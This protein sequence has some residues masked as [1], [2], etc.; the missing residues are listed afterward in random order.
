MK[1]IGLKGNKL[2][3]TDL[4]MKKQA[5]IYILV[6]Q[7]L[8]FFFAYPNNTS[9]WNTLSS[10]LFRLCALKDMVRDVCEK[11]PERVDLCVPFLCQFQHL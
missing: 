6:S 11:V 1:A 4:I 7:N 3:K 10:S 5:I 9:H 2:V 8:K